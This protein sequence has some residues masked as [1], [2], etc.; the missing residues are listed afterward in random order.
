[1]SLD[2]SAIMLHELFSSYVRA[3]F[4]AEQ[5]MQILV[6]QVVTNMQNIKRAGEE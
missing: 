1:M 6:A 3:G 2:D 4:T 5:A